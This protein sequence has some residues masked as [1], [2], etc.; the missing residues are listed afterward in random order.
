MHR[1]PFAHGDARLAVELDRVAG[2]R[3]RQLAVA[4]ID[5]DGG[6]RTAF[7][8]SDEHTRFEVGSV[9]KAFTGMLLAEAVRRGEVTLESTVGLLVPTMSGSPLGS[10][11]LRELC[12]HT[13]G[14]PRLPRTLNMLVQSI[15]SA[16]FGTNP[17]RA[18]SPTS[19]LRLAR[20]QR[21][22][23]RGQYRY[24]NLGATV[25]GLA[26]ATAAGCD[27]PTLLFERVCAP[28]GMGT[29]RIATRADALSRGWTSAGRRSRPW[30]LGGYAPAG[31][32]VS[33]IT[34]LTLLAIAMVEGT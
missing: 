20:R 12:T 31:G 33:T 28:I 10:V 23:Q 8:G 25:L 5:L 17:Y 2:R 30:L 3:T 19:V 7:I 27:F 26:L 13:S 11:T 4:V 29:T 16:W 32:A 6:A 22:V 21:L 34:D 14:L 15:C 24:S 18:L 9:T 1:V